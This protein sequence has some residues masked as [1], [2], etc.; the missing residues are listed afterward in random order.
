M[1]VATIMSTNVITIDVDDDLGKAKQVFDQHNIHH[2]IVK[3]GGRIA[4]ILTDRDLYK[5]LSPNIGTKK[6]TPKD[7]S[8]LQK[9]I[10]LVM[11]R[12]PVTIHENVSLNKA[13]LIFFDN[14]ISC[15]P[16]VDENNIPKGII[17]WRDII[18]VLALKYR[19]KLQSKAS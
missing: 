9:K 11:S 14:H 15:L 10:H 18:K 4:G 19:K 2:I 8:L 6:E 7:T 16:I 3:D 1:S 17:T 5:H 13:V 12:N